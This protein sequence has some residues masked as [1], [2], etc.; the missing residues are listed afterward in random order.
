MSTDRVLAILQPNYKRAYRE[1]FDDYTHIS[2]FSDVSICDFLEAN[3]FRVIDRQPGFLPL[4]VKSRFPVIPA[5]IRAYLLSPIKP[6]AKQMLIRSV[7]A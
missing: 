1:Y 6:F 7:P 5:L 3:Q 2:V 4:S